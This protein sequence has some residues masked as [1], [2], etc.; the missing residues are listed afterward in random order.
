MIF[1]CVIIY[2]S[3]LCGEGVYATVSVKEGIE[4][5][6]NVEE[7]P[8]D[9]NVFFI[10]DT[11]SD[12]EISFFTNCLVQMQAYE[13]ANKYHIKTIN[14]YSGQ[15]PEGWGHWDKLYNIYGED[16]ENYVDEWCILHGID[17]IWSYDIGT[18]QWEQFQR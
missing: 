18:N 13:I 14:G 5:I 3:N 7:P 12:A 15:F 4:D 1:L 11:S 2:T 9:C 6:C 8:R 17:R 10:K 16:Y